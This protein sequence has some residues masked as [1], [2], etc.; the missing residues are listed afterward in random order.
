M[1]GTLLNCHSDADS[2]LVLFPHLC[3]SLARCATRGTLGELFFQIQQDLSPYQQAVAL[4]M[5]IPGVQ[6]ETAACILGEIGADLS[7]FPS[8]TLLVSVVEW[9]HE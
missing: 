1:A 3:L 2:I 8:P 9:R 4:L 7:A 5:R 6:A